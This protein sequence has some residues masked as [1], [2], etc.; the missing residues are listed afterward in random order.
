MLTDRLSLPF[1]AGLAPP[2]GPAVVFDGTDVLLAPPFAAD[3][4]HVTGFRPAWDRIAAAGGRVALEAPAGAAAIAI[5]C[6]LRDREAARSRIAE[7]LR[8]LAP[9]GWLLL[10]GQKTDGVDT[11][12]RTLRKLL[13]VAGVAAK[14][15]GKIA[16]IEHPGA[17]PPEIPAWAEAGRTR[18]NADGL[19]TAPGMFSA[20]RVDPGTQLLIEH[21]PADAKGRAADLGA[22]WGALGMA[23]L[24]RAPGLESC[25]LIEA[26]HAAA[27]AARA[28]VTDPRARVHWADATAWTGGPYDLIVSNPP[29]HVSR[30]ADPSLGQAFIAAAPR[31]L[32]PRGRL[33]LVANRQLPYERTLDAHFRKREILV[34]DSRYKILA[35]DQPRRG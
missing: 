6:L 12:I 28:N 24:A 13:P 11:M 9:G 14:A 25:D 26:E 15:H 20:A 1:E 33:L 8:A 23:L 27:E 16:W 32:T 18:A 29:F 4:L 7:A 17:L 21:L 5:V 2:A 35:A 31:L 22:G 19:L 10:D 30:A 3:V 34:A